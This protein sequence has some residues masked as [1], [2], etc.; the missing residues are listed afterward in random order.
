MG[1]CWL[2]C[3][4]LSTLKDELAH[5]TRLRQQCMPRNGVYSDNDINAIC[6]VLGGSIGKYRFSL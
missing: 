2:I 6:D 1:S 5:E 4:K 3:V